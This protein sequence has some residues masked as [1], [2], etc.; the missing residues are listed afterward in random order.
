MASS[1]KKLK[2]SELSTYLDELSDSDLLSESDSDSLSSEEAEEP[3]TSAR[4]SSPQVSPDSDDE[5][6]DEVY[7]KVLPPEQSLSAP[8]TFLEQSGPKHM[9]P[10]DSHPIEYFNLFFTVS[11]LSLMA[12]ETNRYA[13][14][15]INSMG[16][17]PRYLKKWKPV[18]IKEI[19][20]FLAFL[21]AMGLDK[22]ST[23][24]DYWSTLPPYNN[25]WYGEL[26]SRHRF[27]H[28]LRFFHLVDKSKL[29]GPGELGYDPCARYQPLED[30]ANKV[31]RQHYT[32]HQ[33][34]CVDESLVGTKIHSKI[35]QYQPNKKHHKWGI[36]LWMLCDSVSH[37]CLGFFTYKGA[38]FQA[39]KHRNSKFGLG[40][41]VVR[42]LL[43]LG[44]Y[45]HKGYHVF[46]DN[47]FMSTP[48]IRSLYSRSTYC[49]GTVRKS[50][51]KMLPHFKNKFAVGQIMYFRSGPILACGFRERKSQP[52][53]VFLLSSHARA[54]NNEIVRRGVAKFKPQVVLSY[55]KFMGGVD[56]HDMMLY[57]YL[58][59]RRTKKYWK[60]VAFNII[61]RMMLNAYLLYKENSRSRAKIMT[62]KRFYQEIIGSLGREWREEAREAKNPTDPQ[63]PTD[64]RGPIGLR[65][66]PGRSQYRCVVCSTP[67]NRKT[68]TR[69]CTR[70]GKGVH[71]DCLVK[72]HC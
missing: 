30:H 19:K 10:S 22:K 40:Y 12:T 45:D 43:K 27:C 60:K 68:S 58:D 14:Q 26:F 3:S 13:K 46:V 31:F 34:I 7:L 20:G 2:E 11:L 47:Y 48:L 36:K 8:F 51:K 17:V 50:K 57:T 54:H 23:I 56:T 39:E 42:R 41:T 24:A 15:V 32:P 28:L 1:S 6:E 65:K 59:E 37:Y 63:G 71:A 66:L 33:E 69:V 70:C 5:L 53:P 49:T 9:P 52:K 62:H 35:L 67:N 72:H 44:N 18:T 61:A 38:K 16:K 25:P 4:P 29:P 21:F 55:N 64:P